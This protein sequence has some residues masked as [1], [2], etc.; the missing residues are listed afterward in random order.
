M[1]SVGRTLPVEAEPELLEFAL[2]REGARL[3]CLRGTELLKVTLRTPD[4]FLGLKGV[5][6]AQVPTERPHPRLGD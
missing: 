3:P 6:P 4:P 2:Y 5:L 1:L